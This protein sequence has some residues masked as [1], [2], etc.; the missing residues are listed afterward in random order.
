MKST[1]NTSLIL[2]LA[3]TAIATAAESFG[4]HLTGTNDSFANTLTEVAK[5]RRTKAEKDAAEEIVNT[6]EIKNALV[7]AN[8]QRIAGLEQEIAKIKEQSALLAKAEVYGFATRN[9]LPLALLS[10][11]AAP[12]GARKDLLTIP[13]DWVAPSAPEAAAPA[14][15]TT[16]A[17]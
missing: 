17:A 10:G 3:D 13:K 7:L 4:T 11:Q 6:I 8:V 9:F 5:E 15:N 16:A 1:I 2:V 12:A 14:A